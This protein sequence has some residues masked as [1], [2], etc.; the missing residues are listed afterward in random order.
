VFLPLFELPEFRVI[1]IWRRPLDTIYSGF[2]RFFRTRTRDVPGFLA[3]TRAYVRG[4]RHIRWQLRRSP[5]D[6]C[7]GLRYEALVGRTEATLRGL[8]AFAGLDYCPVDRLLPPRGF[9]DENGKWKR[10][11][12]S[13]VAGGIASARR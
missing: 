6:R 1:V 10:A 3:A 11:L 13:A 2:R 12:R 8:Y 4:A 9:S 5:P 7:L